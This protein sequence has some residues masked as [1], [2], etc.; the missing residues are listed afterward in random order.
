MPRVS[1]FTAA[2]LPLTGAETVYLVQGGNSR[3]TTVEDVVNRALTVDRIVSRVK[4]Q[5]A[6]VAAS[7]TSI[8]FTAI[9][10]W[11]Q[12]ITVMFDG[13]STNGTSPVMI[14][15]GDAGG[16]ETTG[17]AGSSSSVSSG[18]AAAVNTPASGFQIGAGSQAA[19]FVRQGPLFL[20][21]MTGNTWVCAGWVG[22]SDAAQIMSVS[23][24]KTLSANLDR[25]RITTVG[26]TETFDLGSVNISWE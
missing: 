2:S 20:Q 23:G 15:I 16:I 22:Q 13:F 5:T 19:T 21:K 18:G 9:P 3:K 6:V 4:P 24:S 7:Q 1:D 12:R 17:Y 14:Q 25:V 11:V 26:G 10:A 8:D